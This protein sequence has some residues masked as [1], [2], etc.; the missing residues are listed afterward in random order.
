[1]N[2]NDTSLYYIQHIQSYRVPYKISSCCKWIWRKCTQREIIPGVNSCLHGNQSRWLAVC[3]RSESVF[4]TLRWRG[5]S[6]GSWSKDS[7]VSCWNDWREFMS[8]SGLCFFCFSISVLSSQLYHDLP[9]MVAACSSPLTTHSCQL[10]QSMQ[11]SSS[12]WSMFITSNLL[13]TW[14]ILEPSWLCIEPTRNTV[15]S[16]RKQMSLTG[17]IW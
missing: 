8:I 15:L 3:S 11:S 5:L 1:M 13:Y 7:T 4:T 14:N 6:G 17:K 12:P 2:S 10:I 9:C 16:N